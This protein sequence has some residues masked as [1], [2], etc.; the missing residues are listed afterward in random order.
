MRA[1]LQSQRGS[2]LQQSSYHFIQ[3]NN[4]EKLAC[5]ESISHLRVR[6]A[7]AT[8]TTFQQNAPREIF[9]IAKSTHR[10]SENVRPR[11]T[12]AHDARTASTHTRSR[13]P[14]LMAGPSS[15]SRTF[16]CRR[17]P[18]FGSRC[19]L[20]MRWIRAIR[21]ARSLT[22]TSAFSSQNRKPISPYIGNRD[23]EVLSRRFSLVRLS[24]ELTEREVAV[25]DG[26][27][28]AQ[29]GRSRECL[30]VRASGLLER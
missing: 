22:S 2:P 30:A 23:L 14:D 17:W 27:A 1:V 29:L 7:S 16:L 26:Q 25:P 21:Q 5:C 10:M 12:V 15:V 4:T 8:E 6:T 13:T 24:I 3:T 19:E 11:R 20:H 18:T 9:H 28:Q